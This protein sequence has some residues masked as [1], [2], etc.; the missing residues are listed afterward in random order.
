ML[1]SLAFTSDR[2][3]AILFLFPSNFNSQP[4]RV[5][6]LKSVS[7]ES[8]EPSD[9][10]RADADTLGLTGTEISALKYEKMKGKSIEVH[11]GLQSR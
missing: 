4:F 7:K 11:A 9:S 1:S 10:N 5:E 8:E 6:G 3:P 2:V